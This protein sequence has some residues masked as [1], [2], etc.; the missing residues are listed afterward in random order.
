[1]SKRP[2]PEEI[3][4]GICINGFMT[5]SL[6]MERI[7]DAIRAERAEADR[8]IKELEEHYQLASDAADDLAS[9][10]TRLE[11]THVSKEKVRKTLYE[12]LDDISAVRVCMS[13]G[14]DATNPGARAEERAM[15]TPEEAAED[16]VD[17]R[18]PWS[19]LPPADAI[20]ARDAEWQARIAELERTHVSRERVK[21]FLENVVSNLRLGERPEG[22]A[23]AAEVV[24]GIKLDGQS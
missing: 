18:L 20:R 21:G 3:A 12:W 10:A 23:H 24:L 17:P 9:E 11:R 22:V 14:I 6:C 4:E 2:S 16:L 1:M 8:R 13:L 15:K 5:R 19:D 7:A